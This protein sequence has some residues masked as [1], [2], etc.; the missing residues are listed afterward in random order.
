MTHGRLLRTALA[1]MAFAALACTTDTQPSCDL[2]ASGAAVYGTVTSTSGAS[3]Q[4]VTIK[5]DVRAPDCAGSLNFTAG[6]QTDPSGQYVGRIMV[7]TAPMTACVIVTATPGP[8][9]GLAGAVDTVP[10]LDFRAVWQPGVTMD[11][12]RVDFV[13]QPLP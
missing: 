6:T 13:L 2:C 8:T 1:P 3:L 10:E 4:R 5:F 12:A 7:L 11:Q 9:T